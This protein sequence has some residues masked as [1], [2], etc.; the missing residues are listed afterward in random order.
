VSGA[1]GCAGAAVVVALL[2]GAVTLGGLEAAAQRRR[3]FVG[4]ILAPGGRLW[5]LL[6]P[7]AVMALG[8]GVAGLGLALLLVVAV[9][10]GGGLPL[11]LLADVLLMALLVAGLRRLLAGEVQAPHRHALAR[12]WAARLNTLM[13]WVAASGWLLAAPH[14]RWA[15]MSWEAVVAEAAAG[16]STGCA[17]LGVLA[18]GAAAGEALALWAAQ[19]VLTGLRD[20]VRALLAWLAFLGAFGA[21]WILAW[22]WSRALVGVLARP[23][24]L[25]RISE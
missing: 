11:L 13:L 6:R 14:P 5:R 12:R 25:W 20:P 9:A 7:G 15:G 23:W 2:A 18:R 8:Q 16:V 4:Q 1:L 10:R 17:A 24:E 22:A 21:S 19:E 3:A